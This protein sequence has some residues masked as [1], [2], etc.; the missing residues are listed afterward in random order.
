M[1][2][3]RRRVARGPDRASRRTDFAERPARLPHWLWFVPGRIEVFGKH[4]DYAGGRSLLCTVPRGI[5]VAARPRA[6]RRSC[7]SIDLQRSRDRRRSI[8]PPIAPAAARS[9]QLRER[10][11]SAPGVELSGCRRLEPSIAILSDLPRAAGVS[12]SSALVV[13]IASALIRRASLDERARVARQH[14]LDRRQGLVPRLRRERARASARCR[15]RRASARSAGA[16]ITRPSSACRAG[17]VSQ[18]R[19][20]PVHHIGDVVMPQRL[21]VCR[22]VERCARRQG[23]RRSRALQPRVTRDAGAARDLESGRRR[24]RLVSLGEALDSETP[25]R[26]P[27]SMTLSTAETRGG[28]AVEALQTRLTHFT[29]EDARVPAAA[30]AF[31]TADGSAIGELAADSQR[32]CRR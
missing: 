14:H 5:A 21:D 1:S 29:R 18:Y 28:F 16:R 4:T 17:H 31:A 6:R 23:R 3:A 15:A 26:R 11:R 13:G 10:G 9:R 8:W 22:G 12:S 7:A 24:S 27:R 32:R 30:R 25:A 19:F 20:V 2:D